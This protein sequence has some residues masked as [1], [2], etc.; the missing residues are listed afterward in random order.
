GYFRS[1]PLVNLG[2]GAMDDCVFQ[3]HTIRVDVHESSEEFSTISLDP[4]SLPTFLLGNCES[5]PDG[6][7]LDSFFASLGI[8]VKALKHLEHFRLMNDDWVYFDAENAFGAAFP[9]DPN[10]YDDFSW[11]KDRSQL[12]CLK[13]MKRSEYD[14]VFEAA[15]GRFTPYTGFEFA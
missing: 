2:W 13:R 5:R 10:F 11:I 9:K 3:A 1:L 14:A 4:A 6:A 12:D 8:N 7:A 15:F